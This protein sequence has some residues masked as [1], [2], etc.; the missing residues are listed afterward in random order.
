MPV[1]A[2]GRTQ[3]DAAASPPECRR[4]EVALS[5][6]KKT[7]EN[8]HVCPGSKR[9][10]WSQQSPSGARRFSYPLLRKPSL[11]PSGAERLRLVSFRSLLFSGC[12]GLA[13][14]VFLA[15]LPTQLPWELALTLCPRGRRTAAVCA[16]GTLDG[17]LLMAVDL[18]RHRAGIFS[19]IPLSPDDFGQKYEVCFHASLGR[20]SCGHPAFWDQIQLH[21]ITPTLPDPVGNSVS[22]TA[23]LGVLRSC[24]PPAT[25]VVPFP[26]GV[27]AGACL[28]QTPSTRGW[29][30]LYSGVFPPGIHATTAVSWF[31]F[32]TG[33]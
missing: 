30:E 29:R 6:D 9:R 24:V 33:A 21:F 31:L 10:Q 3:A 15:A 32:P 26:H 17:P 1:C 16:V 11:S 19:S 5:V 7:S 8:D 2:P 25:N 12:R 13:L 28:P 23:Y 4:W 27:V 14:A 18:S 22:F 20:P